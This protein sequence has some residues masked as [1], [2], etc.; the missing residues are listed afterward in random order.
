MK[1]GRKLN[2]NETC[3]HKDDNFTNDSRNNL[4]VLTR[5]ENTEKQAIAKRKA[6]VAERNTHQT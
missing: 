3:D 2:I 6:T 5:K 4:Q 1:I